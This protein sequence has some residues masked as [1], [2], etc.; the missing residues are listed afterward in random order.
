MY[1]TFP[2]LLAETIMIRAPVL[3]PLLGLLFL[4]GEIAASQ[5]LAPGTV[6]VGVEAPSAAVLANRRAASITNRD[7]FDDDAGD[8]SGQPA[9]HYDFQLEPATDL[10][11]LFGMF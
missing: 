3:S 1:P 4:A 10:R 5:P 7:S 2:V 9:G 6:L 11:P 8:Q